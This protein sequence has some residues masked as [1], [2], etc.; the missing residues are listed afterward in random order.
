[1][2]STKALCNLPDREVRTALSTALDRVAAI[3]ALEQPRT[4]FDATLRAYL[5]AVR[6]QPGSTAS[7]HR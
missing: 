4:R 1:M 7:L 6:A 2:T 3:A 5:K